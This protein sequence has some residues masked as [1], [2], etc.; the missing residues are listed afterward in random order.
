FFAFRA[1]LAHGARL[2]FGS[3]WPIVSPDPLLGIKAAVTGLDLDGRPF[4]TE[5]SISVEAALAAYTRV[6]AEMLGFPGGMLREGRAADLV[7]LDRSP[8]ELDW[9]REMPKVEATIV[10]GRVVHGDSAILG[11]LQRERN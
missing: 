1:L 4:A 5:H 11:V 2:A 10:G 9:T 6:P 3:D 8:F 7:L